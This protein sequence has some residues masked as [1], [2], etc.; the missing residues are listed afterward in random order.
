VPHFADVVSFEWLEGSRTFSILFG[1]VTAGACL[2]LAV[3]ILYWYLPGT[4]KSLFGERID[5]DQRL[6]FFFGILCMSMA[7]TDALCRYIP[8]RPLGWVHPAFFLTTV[9]LVALLGPRV[10]AVGSGNGT[11][12]VRLSSGPLFVALVALAAFPISA[13]V[14]AFWY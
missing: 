14:N 10:Y 5:P 12:P 8:H 6:Q 13:V 4:R 3:P 7:F 11:G 1:T 2:S 9:A